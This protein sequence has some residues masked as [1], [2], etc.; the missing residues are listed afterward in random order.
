[1]VAPAVVAGGSRQRVSLCLIVKNEEAN[2]PDCLA[3]AAGLADEVVVVDT[4]SADRTRELAARAGARV[5]DFAWVDDFAAARNE[6]LR[7]A[8][9]DWIFWLDADDRLDEVN[10]R[11]LRDL[12]AGLK[13]ENA[14]YVMKCLCLSDPVAG[15]ETVVDHIRLFRNHP[16]VRWQYRVHEQIL[17]S[18][19]RL[20]SE[21]RW[22][23]LVIHHLGYQDPTLRRRKLERDLRLL[24]HES[25]EH[26]DDPFN[27]FNLG[28]VYQ[29]LGRTEEALPLLRR[30]LNRSN[31]RASIVRKLYALIAQG[32]RQLGQ[33]AEALAACREGRSLYPD[34]AELLFQES[35]VSRQLGDPATAESCLLRLLEAREGDHF[36]SIDPGLRGYKARHNLAVLYHQQGRETEAEDQWRAALDERP[37]FGPAWLGLGE[38][39]LRSGRWNDLESIARR[40]ETNPSGGV[41][42]D[43]LRARGHLARREFSAARRLLEEVVSRAPRAL[44]PRVVLSHVLL[45][46]GG[47][48]AAAEEAL[49]GILAL[50]PSNTEA[51][52][53]LSVL[54][55]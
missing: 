1:M 7:H 35:L 37:D 4:G 19:R 11:K 8:T 52:H 40:L 50:D 9:G 39:R 20:G 15:G 12:L 47:D 6:S 42:A 14:A 51:R 10:R 30:S 45:Q 25:V 36:S 54:R 3:S 29:E 27:L 48:R 2:L 5:F 18:I 24:Q 53:N 44:A 41:D 49:Q 55:R 31:P 28:S 23:D 32:H 43:L 46:E 16:E 17:P 38:I 21:V 34:D 26:P 13:D 22:A 33:G